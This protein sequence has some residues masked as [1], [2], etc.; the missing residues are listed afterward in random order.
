MDYYSHSSGIHKVNVRTEALL[1]EALYKDKKFQAPWDGQPHQS[2][3]K[4]P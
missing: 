3:K 2:H 1:L 4:F